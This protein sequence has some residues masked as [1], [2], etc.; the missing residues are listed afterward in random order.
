MADK[1]E[2]RT[3]RERRAAGDTCICRPVRGAV[4]DCHG[5]PLP[6]VY[7][8]YARRSDVIK[9]LAHPARLY[10]IDRLASCECSVRE[11]TELIGCEMPT[12]SRHL[13]VLRQVGIVSGTKRGS[14]VF[15]RLQ[16]PC[17]LN[18]FGCVEEVLN[19]DGGSDAGRENNR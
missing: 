6:E 15:Y 8:R 14:H 3:A 16:V 1:A 10:I 4:V 18:F 17:I 7:S 12:V 19:Q 2:R 9:A 13:S 11:L 5:E